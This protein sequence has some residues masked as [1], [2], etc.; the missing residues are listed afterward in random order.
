MSLSSVVKVKREPSTPLYQSSAAP[1]AGS[2]VRIRAK[3]AVFKLTEVSRVDGVKDGAVDS[4][5]G[6]AG[7]NGQLLD[8]LVVVWVCVVV[9]AIGPQLE[10]G[11]G[12]EAL[13]QD[14]D[15]LQGLDKG[16]NVGCLNLGEGLVAGED[17]SAGVGAYS[18]L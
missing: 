4:V 9:I 11:V 1:E 14:R 18:S 8:L 12:V 10:L 15:G 16:G 5:D 13:G 2:E 3:F 17:V 7:V 6:V